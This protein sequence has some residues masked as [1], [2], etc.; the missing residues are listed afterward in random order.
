MKV[1]LKP[2]EADALI[3]QC[4]SENRCF[5]VIAGAGSGK[6][7]SLIRTLESIRDQKGAL[8]RRTGQRVVCLTFTKR[9]V[10]VIRKRLRWDD[11]FIVSTLHSF[12]WGEIGR[13]S[14]DIQKALYDDVVP[15]HIA[16]ARKDDDGKATKKAAA[17]REKA[18]KLE[19]QREAL[20]KVAS[21]RY[22][23]GPY[24]NYVEGEL[25]HDDV[26]AVAASLIRSRELLRRLIGQ[27]YPYIFVDEAQDTHEEIVSALNT[28]CA[29]AGL[30]LVGYF[31]DPMQQ[32]YDKRAGSFE[33]PPNSL[34]IPKRENFRC[35]NEVVKLL[36]AFRDDLQQFP[37]GENS[38][39]EG[40]IKIR[41]ISTETPEL[42]RGRYSPEQISRATALLDKAISDWG[43]AGQSDV[44]HLY[45]VRQMIARRLGF[46]S[47]HSLFDGDYASQKAKEEFETGDYFL[48]KPFVSC[49]YPLV[50]AFRS[51]NARKQVDILR[52]HAPAFD[53]KGVNS[54]RT[55]AEMMKIALE[56]TSKLTDIWGSGTAGD[57]LRY[58]VECG[59]T[60][61]TERLGKHISRPPRTEAYEETQYGADRQDWL[62]DDFF[63]FPLLEVEKYCEFMAEN[64][65]YSTQHGV[66]GEQY[67]KVFVVFDDIGSAWNQYS[68]SGLLTPKTSGKE[69]T[70]RQLRLSRNLAYVCFSRALVDLRIVYFTPDASAAA[71]EL[72][73]RGFFTDSQ[74]EVSA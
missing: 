27:K 25:G 22:A 9:A 70:E 41:C 68:F 74:I 18:E 63:K 34:L 36:N 30:P 43:W 66:K 60:K 4:L 12:L 38:K 73:E 16:H 62:V 15:T 19:I 39:I 72:V 2:T 29:D 71:K 24:S 65:V 48:I 13:F 8:L 61:E 14:K 69:P 49:L 32:I 64:T 40:S 46:V 1:E 5:H 11:L 55:L 33:G 6:T 53:P 50:I 10:E 3:D 23:D 57:V 37:A 17:A 21:F 28:V 56:C 31:G 42:P 47:L 52:Q 58:A 7:A 44:K 51:K 20:L 54:K 67:H 26:I 35:S 45:L 59:L